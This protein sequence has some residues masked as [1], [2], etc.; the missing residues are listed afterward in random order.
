MIYLDI[1]IVETHN[2][3]IL[4]IAD[5]SSYA[6]GKNIESPFIEISTPGF[7]KVGLSFVPRSVNIFNSTTLKLTGPDSRPV[8]LPDGV[9]KIRYSIRPAYENY[10]EKSI[11]RLTSLKE[12]FDLAFLQSDPTCCSS[13]EAE[14]IR[15]KLDTIAFYIQYAISAAAICNDHLA[16]DLYRKAV[17]LLEKF[18]C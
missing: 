4:A 10:T 12:R 5:V 7:D 8:K 6:S 9:Y 1:A 18:N 14:K 17:K 11:L 2:P 3:A 16:M 13:R 15:R